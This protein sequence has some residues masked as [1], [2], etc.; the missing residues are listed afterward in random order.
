MKTKNKKITVTVDASTWRWL[1]ALA[2]ANQKADMLLAP[3][4]REGILAQAAFCFAD[5]AGRRTGS[6]E[7]SVGQSLLDSSGY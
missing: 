4:T 6:W 1:G 2:R 5:A 7:A 3:S